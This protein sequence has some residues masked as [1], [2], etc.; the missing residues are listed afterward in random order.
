[1]PFI[2]VN[3]EILIKLKSNKLR[4]NDDNWDE[5]IDHGTKVKSKPCFQ[6]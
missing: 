6:L 2:E 3:G 4:Y 1:M 5:S